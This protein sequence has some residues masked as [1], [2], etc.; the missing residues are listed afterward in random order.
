LRAAAIRIRNRSE[1]MPLAASMLDRFGNEN[2]FSAAVMH[3]LNVALD[4]ALANI[5]AYGYDEGEI[6]E[7]EL[8]FEYREREVA[9][10]IEDCGRKFDPTQVLK[11]D[12]SG[13]LKTR[14]IGG[15]GI[16]FMRSLT[17]TM[18]YTCIGTKN[19]L[20]LTKKMID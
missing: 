13:S 5:I 12:L 16:H 8:R 1:D 6:G 19:R 2:G 7:I 14:K 18:S 3:D 20:R 9:I 10:E 17:D 11:P 4:E 15:V